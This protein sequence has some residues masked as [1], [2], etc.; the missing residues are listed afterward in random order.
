MIF[1]PTPPLFKECSRLVARLLSLSSGRRRK[2]PKGELGLGDGGS[3]PLG[4]LHEGER[5]RV[6]RGQDGEKTIPTRELRPEPSGHLLDEH[7]FR[8]A[9]PG[10][11]LTEAACSRWLVPS[12]P[13]REGSSARRAATNRV[14]R[15]LTGAAG[16]N[17]LQRC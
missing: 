4:L 6:G 14:P 9:D 5:G 2:G 13:G 8:P 15:A 1:S 3:K 12:L 16:A 11:A 17:V 10:R 7:A